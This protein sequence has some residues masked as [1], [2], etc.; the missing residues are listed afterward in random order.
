MLKNILKITL[1]VIPIY[2]LCNL[3]LWLVSG[4]IKLAFDLGIPLYILFW[5]VI[6]LATFFLMRKYENGAISLG[7]NTQGLT[8]VVGVVTV[9]III[10]VFLA[11]I[12]NA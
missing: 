6:P 8:I 3:I 2:F 7:R 11:M 12:G 5:I 9:L 10:G 4:K 1:I